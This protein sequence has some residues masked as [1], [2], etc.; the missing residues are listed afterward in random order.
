ML[1]GGWYHIPIVVRL[2]SFYSRDTKMNKREY[3]TKE[4]IL[5]VT[6]FRE[7]SVSWN[8]TLLCS[9][10]K[11]AESQFAAVM[12]LLLHHRE[13]GV[14]RDLLEQTLFEDRDVED[15][16]HALRSVIYNARQNLKKSG[17]PEAEY[18]CLKKGIYYWTEAIPVQ[19]DAAEMERLIREAHG[20]TDPERKKR[21][22]LEACYLYAGEFLEN[23][24]G[25]TWIA[26]EA[27]RYRDM[28]LSCLQETIGMLRAD[29]AYEQMER[30]GR[31]AAKLYPLKNWELVVMEALTAAGRYDEAV[32]LYEDTAELY[33]REQQLKPSPQLMHMLEELGNGMEHQAAPLEEIQEELMG[34]SAGTGTQRVPYPVFRG[35]YRFMERQ[36]TRE[37]TQASL[38]L[39]TVTDA[40]GNAM[41]RGASLDVMS[42]RLETAIQQSIRSSDVYTRIGSG[43]YL[44]LLSHTS[45]GQCLPVQNRIN[46]NFLKGRQK[47]GVRFRVNPVPAVH[48]VPMPAASVF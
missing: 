34:E 20:E 42:A 23:Q 18:I 3:N 22:L 36:Y 44:I 14:S 24:E 25:R 35:I 1:R 8:G 4:N 21:L 33:L 45:A 11:A 19:E 31:Y 5:R 43:Q 48:T 2:C 26:H 9:S 7:F 15:M 41:R 10:R 12:E 38:M 16:H 39:C 29:R 46:R 27:R 47:T 40:R 37:H 28:F 32:R 13:T 17:L 6:M 30:L